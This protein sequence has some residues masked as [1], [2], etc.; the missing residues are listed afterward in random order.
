[1][2]LRGVLLKDSAQS[3]WGMRVLKPLLCC[4]E[5]TEV[6]QDTGRQGHC[7]TMSA[8]GQVRLEPGLPVV[9][10]PLFFFSFTP[11]ARE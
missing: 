2:Q 9:L 10:P 7:L 3:C 6:T 1:M 8:R 4:Q 11:S 5:V